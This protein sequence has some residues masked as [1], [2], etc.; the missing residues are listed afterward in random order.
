MYTHER[1]QGKSCQI[2]PDKCGTS[3]ILSR[4][5]CQANITCTC[6]YVR[7][8]VLEDVNLLVLQGQFESKGRMVVLQDSSTGQRYSGNYV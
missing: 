1:T 6:A 7:V 2:S 3:D 4:R 5:C 8:Q